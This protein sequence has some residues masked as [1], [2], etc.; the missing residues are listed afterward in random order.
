MLIPC[1]QGD[2]EDKSCMPA[3][4]ARGGWWLRAALCV[5]G[6]VG[7]RGG[8]RA[9]PLPHVIAMHVL[10]YIQWCFRNFPP[11]HPP[12]SSKGTWLCIH[13]FVFSRAG[14]E[15]MNYESFISILLSIEVSQVKFYVH[16]DI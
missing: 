14:S 9:A 7:Q 15:K 1:A 5:L 11:S 3:L 6:N 2:T 16:W 4:W 10:N 8:R 13:L 12:C